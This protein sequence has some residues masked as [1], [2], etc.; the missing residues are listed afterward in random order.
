MKIIY[1]GHSA[2][3]LK[4]KNATVVTDPFEKETVGFKM[5]KAEADIVTVSH[6][7]PDHNATYLVEGQKQ[8]FDFPG[9]YERKGVRIYGY[10]TYHDANKGQDR[11]SNIM[12]KI[13][14]DGII[15][16]HCGDLGHL[17]ENGC[18]EEIKDVDVLM[19][20][21][22]GKVTL[23]SKEVVKLIEMVKPEVIIPM[24]YKTEKH[25]QEN[26]AGFSALT[27]FL[28]LVNAEKIQPVDSLTL[29]ASELPERE[30]VL[31]NF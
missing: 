6:Q 28:K 26:F 14:L 25:H 4:G 17:P 2:F 1:L 16:L 15:F 8:V 23:P 30:V 22:G 27:E 10:Q 11:G 19:V 31:F 20:P 13:I 18:I 24:H 29:N 3:M 9:E 21:V 5:H 7:H 12:F